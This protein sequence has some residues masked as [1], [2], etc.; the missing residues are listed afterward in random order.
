[1]TGGALEAGGRLRI[2]AGEGS[3]DHVESA[4]Q[5]GPLTAPLAMSDGTVGQLQGERPVA[6]ARSDGASLNGVRCGCLQVETLSDGSGLC[7]RAAG[8]YRVG[9]GQGGSQ[10]Y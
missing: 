6:Q 8:L 3:G 10:R 4:G 2:G 7:E 5:V 1:M 9:F